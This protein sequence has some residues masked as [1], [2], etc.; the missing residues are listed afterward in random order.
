MK[1]GEPQDPETRQAAARSAAPCAGRGARTRPRRD[2]QSAQPLPPRRTRGVRRRLVAAGGRFRARGR[3]GLSAHD[4][5]D[6]AGADHHRAQCVARHSVQSVDQS[7][8]G[9]RARLHLLL[10]ATHARL[11][12]PVAGPRLRDEALRQAQCRRRCCARSSRSPAIA[13]TRSR[14]APTPIRTSRSSA[15]GR[16]R[17]AILEVL[18]EHE[19]P[20]TIVTK[21]ALVERDL[22]LIAP[23]AAKNM[24]R[25]YISITTLDRE[26]ARSLEPRAAA[27]PR[28][29]QTIR[30]LERRRRAG[31]RAGRAGDSAAQRPR[32]RGDPRGRRASGARH[33]GWIMLRLPLEVAPLFRDW[34]DAHYPLRAEHVMS[35]LRQLRGGRDYD[36]RFGDA[37]ARHRPVRRTHREAL[38]ARRAGASGSTATAR[39]SIPSRFRAAGACRSAPA[40]PDLGDAERRRE[41][42]KAPSS[43]CTT[44]CRLLERVS[45][46]AVDEPRPRG[47]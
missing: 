31:G 47:S 16:S 28:R 23:M 8:P 15:S 6:P 22:D 19:H 39:R 4:G 46:A 42:A 37:D 24:A 41:P 45:Q 7:V 21:S 3:T 5:H 30:A 17:A 12:R 1:R 38:R 26:L 36:A 35:V 18:C 13:A 34:L 20:F 29:L 14:S 33:A 40:R 32:P 25:V 11:S 2:V 43:R 9:L 44:W 10:C 27:P